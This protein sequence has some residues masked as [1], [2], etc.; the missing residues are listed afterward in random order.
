M[1]ST[2]QD[3]LEQINRILYDRVERFGIKITVNPGFSSY[4]DGNVSKWFFDGI[5]SYH[6]YVRARGEWFLK[7]IFIH[8]VSHI[9]WDIDTK[10][11]PELKIRFQRLYIDIWRSRK[12][13]FRVLS[14]GFYSND[15]EMGHPESS[16]EELFCSLHTLMRMY[17]NQ[18]DS[19]SN[20]LFLNLATIMRYIQSLRD[21][22]EIM[23]KYYNLDGIIDRVVEKQSYPFIPMRWLMFF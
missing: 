21:G 13:I 5:P 15:Y 17:A 10:S 3:P 4:N 18:N 23:Q 12:S 7:M 14:E 9:L 20:L 22:L 8:E 16:P 19:K 1:I 2:V 6:I 11:N